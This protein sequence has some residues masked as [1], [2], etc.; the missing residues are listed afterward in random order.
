LLPER[1]RRWCSWL[2]TDESGV[3]TRGKN[4]GWAGAE[5][6]AGRGVGA[7]AEAEGPEKEEEDVAVLEE[8]DPRDPGL[9]VTSEGS[10]REALP[11]SCWG[12]SAPD[13]TS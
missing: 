5:V 2:C 1:G 9:G 8:E 13:A 4:G 10:D 6:P 12:K 7:E 11:C 3:L